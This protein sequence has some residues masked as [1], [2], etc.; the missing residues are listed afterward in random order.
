MVEAL[1]HRHLNETD[2]FAHSRHNLVA[3]LS[4]MG[5]QNRK[6]L[7]AMASV[8]RHVFV[9][10]QL[11]NLAYKNQSLPIGSGQTIS[12]PYI[13][14]RM[15]EMLISDGYDDKVLEIGT[16]SGYQAA[17]LAKLFTGV[18]TV[19]RRNS[20]FQNARRVLRS[21]ACSNVHFRKGNGTLGWK[22]YAPY[23]AII[24]TAA[25]ERE[26]SRLILEQMAVPSLLVAPIGD[27]TQ[28]LVVIRRSR[29]GWREKR[30]EKVKFVPFVDG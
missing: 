26:V 6:V 3:K 14:A 10:P 12:Q 23:Q 7:E 22:Q 21:Q 1:V 16:G 17:V 30:C 29:L 11:S 8:P 25:V 28:H 18:F 24:I 5:I 2:H 4:D 15:T 20:L 19:E 9:D 13:V 27:E